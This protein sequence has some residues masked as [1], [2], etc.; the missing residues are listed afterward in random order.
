MTRPLAAFWPDGAIMWAGVA[1]T[2]AIFSL[3][4]K[5][6]PVYRF[7]EHLFIGLA[8]GYALS[9]TWNEILRP[10]WWEPM[11]GS[12]AEGGQWWLMFAFLLGLLYYTLYIR[13][14]AWMS[15]LLIGVMMGVGAGLAFQGFVST[16]SPQ[17]AAA[18]TP[19]LPG[20]GL[21]VFQLFNNWV[22]LLTLIAVMTYFFFAFEQQNKAVQKTAKAGRWLLM[23]S[24][25]A[26]FGQTVMARMAL[27]SGRLNFL[28]NDTGLTDAIRRLFGH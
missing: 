4:Y 3:L 6:N 26:I 1:C 9:V 7:F 24:F 16:Y 2:L 21:S 18:F 20:Q 8:T 28:L 11:A 25:G 15:R 17:I 23:I 22:I 12:G 19:L 27:A 13:K 10:K 5:E 14:L